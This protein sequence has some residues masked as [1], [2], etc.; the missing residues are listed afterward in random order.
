[1]K[2]WET[3]EST[4]NYSLF[5]HFAENLSVANAFFLPQQSCLRCDS[6]NSMCEAF[7]WKRADVHLLCCHW[8]VLFEVGMKNDLKSF[9]MHARIDIINDRTGIGT[10]DTQYRIAIDVPIREKQFDSDANL[11][12]MPNKV[13]NLCILLY[14]IVHILWTRNNCRAMHWSNLQHRFLFGFL[15]NMINFAFCWQF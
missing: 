9:S 15:K 14:C 4:E 11:S 6:M 7:M 3:F 10:K 5:C 13:R 1:M 2:Q 8:L 12:S